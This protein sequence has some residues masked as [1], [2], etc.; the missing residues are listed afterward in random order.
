VS[1]TTVVRRTSKS[2]RGAPQFGT[3]RDEK[4]EQPM[5]LW[6]TIV[7]WIK[8]IVS[9]LLIVM[10]INGLLIA[11]FVVPTG[12][13]ENEV[14][15]GD[16]LFVNKFIYGGSSPQTI[17]FF[18]TPLPYFRLPGLRDPE[19]NDVIVFIYPGDRNESEPADFQYYLKRCVAVA[20]DTLQVINSV[21]HLNGVAQPFPPNAQL[22]PKPIDPNDHLM[23]FPENAGYTRD[24]WGPMRVPKEGDVI[25]LNDSTFNMWRVFVLREGHTLERNGDM[26]LLD[27][28]PVTSYKV[29]RDYVFGMGDNRNNSEDSRYWG[30]IPVENVV[31]TPLMVYWSWDQGPDW[32]PYGLGQKIQNIRWGRIFTGID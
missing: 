11:S 4:Q 31:G 5:T 23:T 18:N 9:S 12:S 1:K 15:A 26:I 2:D 24:N 27:G 14:L 25:P 32:A 22:I 19:R 13:M 17:P 29:Q 8:T 30:F 6:E 16:F 7:S 21:V 28:K 20:G 10:V 3:K